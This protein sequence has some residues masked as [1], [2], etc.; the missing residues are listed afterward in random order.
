MYDPWDI[1]WS[2]IGLGGICAL[3]MAAYP[4]EGLLLDE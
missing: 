4:F 2:A 3:L 1:L